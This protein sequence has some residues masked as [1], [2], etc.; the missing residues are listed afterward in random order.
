MPKHFSDDESGSKV[1][2]GV[3]L[4]RI[5]E[6]EEP[7]RTGFPTLPQIALSPTSSSLCKARIREALFHK[8]EPI[9]MSHFVLLQRLGA[10]AM[11]EIYEAFDEQLDR[12]VAL[13]L[14]LQG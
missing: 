9:R 12:R 5:C 3:E 14:V 11:G 1:S 7:S 6:L 8:V 10:G 13:K 4:A 2:R